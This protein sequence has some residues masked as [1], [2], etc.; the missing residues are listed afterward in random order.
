MK[1]AQVI[2][3]PYTL[4]E[5]S[6]VAEVTSKGNISIFSV[7]NPIPIWAMERWPFLVQAS[8]SNQDAQ[9]KVMA[10]IVQSWDW[11][12]V[13][14]IYED[15]TDSAF[16][17]VIPSLLESLQEVGVEISHLVP[18]PSLVTSSMSKE[19]L[20]LKGD[21]YCRVFVVHT[22]LKLATHISKSTRDE[23]DGK[24]LCLDC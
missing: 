16:G 18:L 1:A 4:Q 23:N 21:Q 22:S 17:R 5:A 3:G 14:I 10:A 9:I 2:L 20:R 8:I 15:D 24:R 6:R 7:A 11:R 19:L 13:N 12:R